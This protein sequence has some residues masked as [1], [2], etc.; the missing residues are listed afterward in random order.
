MQT[1]LKDEDTCAALGKNARQTAE[2]FRPEAV[3]RQWEDTVLT[4]I[5]RKERTK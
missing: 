2:R 4:V 1:L 3:F 5:A